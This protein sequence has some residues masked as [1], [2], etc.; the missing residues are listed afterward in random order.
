MGMVKVIRCILL[1]AKDGGVPKTMGPREEGGE[2][3]PH[4]WIHSVQRT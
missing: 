4:I 3:G 2:P 1:R